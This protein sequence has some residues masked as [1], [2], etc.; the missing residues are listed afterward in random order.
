MGGAVSLI[1]SFGGIYSVFFIIIEGIVSALMYEVFKNSGAVKDENFRTVN[2]NSE[3]YISTAVTVGVMVA[4]LNGFDM[5]GVSFTNVFAVYAVLATALN[6]S[7]V[8]AGC[9]GMCI[10]FF[11]CM[12]D[13]NAILMMG[14]YGLNAL[15]A[16]FMNSFKKIG[17]A[18][19]YI[20]GTAVTLIYMRN[21]YDIP[22]SM[23]DTIVG[24]ILFI[25]TPKIIHE[26]LSDFFKSENRVETVEP[27][28]RMR[29]YLKMRLNDAG[30]AFASLRECFMAVSEGRL[31]KYSEDAGM[32]LDET[33]DRVCSGCR[34]CGKCWQN[35]FRKTYKNVLELVAIIETE[36]K[37]T[38]ENIPDRFCEKC[39]RTNVFIGE[40]NHVYEL[41]KRDVL[42]RSDAVATRN[43]LA[44]QY[45]ELE[46]LFHSVSEDIEEGFEFLYDE[47]ERIVNGLNKIG[48]M[49]YAVSA[50]EGM[51]GHCE[52]YLRLPPVARRTA[53]E[54][55]ISDV[56]G[57]AV[58]FEQCMHGLSK[59]ISKPNFSVESAV[60]QIPQEGSK[61][62]GDS[63]TVFVKDGKFY[64]VAADGMGS[65][66]EAQYESAATL[67]LLTS[68]L[69]SGFSVKTAL[70]ILNSAM[71]L[72]MNSEMYST[73]DLF[74][75]DLYTGEA[76]L[77]KIGSAETIIM[78]GDE[79]KTITSSS[80]P[81]G[82]LSDIQLDNKRFKL[83]EGDV[84]LIMTD[85]ITEA[86]Y[87]VSKT[88]WIKQ[89]AILPYENMEDMAE[90]IMDT[91][92]EKEHG[93]AK[94]DMSIIALR[95]MGI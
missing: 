10:G 74:C 32:I 71:C 27:S 21:M 2:I 66:V 18:V 6:S 70:G 8:A 36:G 48:I 85:G 19:G 29:E 39:V 61:V 5:Y 81:V 37:L 93:E 86:G 88:D 91:A 79:I 38:T 14:I 30:E 46:N 16:A 59:Y 41:Y 54:G 87:T 63:I 95:I 12:A 33:A 22:I 75:M 1:M 13:M 78:T 52:V 50:V 20:G 35:D 44:V 84:I 65:G 53:V 68:F 92:I 73:V 60:V 82:I 25:V 28:E 23:T 24:C 26:Y 4:G 83:H 89:T 42:R 31:K 51:S 3:E 62:S 76:E 49:T 43:L 69:K 9:T 58:E 55:V 90:A 80:I 64:A 47:E 94:D 17:C 40:L 67:R 7:V 11:S 15:F 77:Y 72:N 56:L 45:S 34:M 57:C